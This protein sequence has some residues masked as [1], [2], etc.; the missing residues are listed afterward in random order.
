MRRVFFPVLIGIVGVAVLLALGVWQVQR[1]TWKRA[2]LAEIDGRIGAAPV[3]LPV[4]PDEATD[5]YM[6]VTVGG[7]MT[8]PEIHVLV[9]AENVGAGYRVVTAM[10][11]PDGRKILIDRGYIALDADTQDRHARAVTV[12]GNLLWP[13]EVDGWTPDPDL[14]R[15]IW[16]A[17]DLPA[18]AEA[19]GAEPVLVVAR[20]V[21]GGAGTVLLPIDS[22]GI[23]NDHLNYAI[24]WFSLAAVW[25]GMSGVLIARTLRRKD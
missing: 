5:E 11:M 21:A 24:T 2:I 19:L 10:K 18:M 15:N 9:S 13:D 7:D 6:P 12:T 25:A 1:L 22:A 17:R 3:A 16:F 20:E 4:V 23:S 14:G 8:G